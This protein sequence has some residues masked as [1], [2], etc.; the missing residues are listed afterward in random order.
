MPYD[1][2]S[3]TPGIVHLGIGAFCRAHTAMY[4]DSVLPI[5]PSWGIVGASLKRPDTRDAL[6]PQDF[7]YSLIERSAAG[8]KDRIIGSL[9]NVYVATHHREGLIAIMADPRIRIVSL[10][11]TEK[12]YCHDPATG[13]LDESHAEIRHDLEHP[14]APSSV[15]GLIVRAIAMRRLAG[16]APFTVLCCDNLPSNGAT[17]ARIITAFAALRSDELASYVE[18][19][20]AFPSTMV[21]RIV[22]ATTD[23]DRRLASDATG[24]RDRWPVVTEPF[25][26]WV[27]E[28]RFGGERPP[29]ERA[30]VQMVGDVHPYE[31]MKL[32]MLNGSHSTLAYLGYLAGYEYVNTAIADPALRALIH[33]LMTEE[34]MGT[35]PKGLGDLDGYRDA[36]IERFCNPALQHRTWQIAMDGSQKL[37]QRLLGTIRERLAAGLPITRLS[38]GVAAW[39]RF[40]TGV[41]ENGERIEVKDPL[42]PRLRATADAANGSPSELV[43]GLLRVSEVFG[44]DLSSNQ[45]FRTLLLRYVTS[46]YQRGALATASLVHSGTL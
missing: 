33:D 25:T 6:A 42:A 46:L 23:N 16:V 14:N 11:V 45:T 15:P 26:Q 41:G 18:R 8:T 22:P 32:R 9:L 13:K 20:V 17:V 2:S 36:L 4:V 19:S 30:Q 24:L 3:V 7:L 44:R 27:V 35:L 37:P 28:D 39:M 34:V 40:V 1:R 29:L 43:E 12:G 10:T 5:D 38:L 21:D 31:L